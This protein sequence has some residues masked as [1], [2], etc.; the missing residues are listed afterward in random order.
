MM[1]SEKRRVEATKAAALLAEIGCHMQANAV[2][3][4]VS[5]AASLHATARLLHADNMALRARIAELER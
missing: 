3:R 2:R 1:P 5:S 4:L